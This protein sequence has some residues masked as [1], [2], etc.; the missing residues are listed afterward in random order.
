[1]VAAVVGGGRITT[2]TDE[3]GAGR[4]ILVM[5]DGAAARTSAKRGSCSTA[6][7]VA[8]RST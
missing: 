7:N 2:R 3:E 5:T 1:M 8:A 4:S 6:L